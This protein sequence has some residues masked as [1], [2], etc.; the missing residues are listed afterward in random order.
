MV[1]RV[2]FSSCITY[3]NARTV[4]F[5]KS[6]VLYN[7]HSTNTFSCLSYSLI[8]A[9]ISFPPSLVAFVNVTLYPIFLYKAAINI[10]KSL[11]VREKICL[12][13]SDAF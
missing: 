13:L 8:S 5:F 4:S 9:I 6:V 11:E 1:A 10:S 7:L 12:L 2:A 3:P